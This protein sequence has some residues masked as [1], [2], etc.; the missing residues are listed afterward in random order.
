MTVL[1]DAIFNGMQSASSTAGPWRKSS[2]SDTQDHCVEV[3]ELPGG[4][5]AVR[6]SRDP[7]GPA[8]VYTRAEMEAFAAGVK[9]GE[10]DWADEDDLSPRSGDAA[11]GTGPLPADAGSGPP[12]QHRMV[13]DEL[14]RIADTILT[15]EAVLDRQAAERLLRVVGAVVALHQSHDVDEHGQCTTCRPKSRLRWAGRHDRR[16]CSVYATLSTH[17]GYTPI[18]STSSDR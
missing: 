1:V 9:D 5:V 8:L 4:E 14:Q 10:F 7:Q 15:G 3:A 18:P 16:P 17:L 11:T 13:D 2:H 12:A 6:N